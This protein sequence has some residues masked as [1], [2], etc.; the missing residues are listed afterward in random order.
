MPPVAS[1][2]KYI[3]EGVVPCENLLPCRCQQLGGDEPLPIL[4]RW[5]VD[6]LL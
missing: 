4:Y 5:L 6:G 2:E 1:I 3:D